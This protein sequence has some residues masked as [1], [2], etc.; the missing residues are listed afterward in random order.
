MSA[1]RPWAGLVRRQGRRQRGMGLG[2]ADLRRRHTAAAQGKLKGTVLLDRQQS[3][4]AAFLL[5]GFIEST[6][7]LM[8]K[9]VRRARAHE[10]HYSLPQVQPSSTRKR[11]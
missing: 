2:F 8:W 6:R 5:P 9:S 7:S 10:K 1:S 4:V 3:E 11:H